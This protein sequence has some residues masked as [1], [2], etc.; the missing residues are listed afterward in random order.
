MPLLLPASDEIEK[1]CLLLPPPLLVLLL[2]GSSTRLPVLVL[3]YV[4]VDDSNS[5]AF[6]LM[7]ARML[8][9]DTMM[10]MPYKT[11]P[12]IPVTRNSLREGK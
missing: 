8:N 7:Y 3:L 5:F 4:R 2:A 11:T 12:R 1:E 6:A 10:R 9:A